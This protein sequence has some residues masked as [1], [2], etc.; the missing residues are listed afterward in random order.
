[1]NALPVITTS[2]SKPL[3][4]SG[5]PSTIS[6]TGANTYTWS[7]N[8]TGTATVVNPT[9]ATVYVVTGKESATG[10]TN[11]ATAQVAVFIPTFALTSNTS[12]CIGG[13]I[14]LNGSGA[15][16]YTWNADPTKTTPFLAVSP[17]VATI[18]TLTGKSTSVSVVC[19]ADQTVQVGI[20]NQPTVTA[21]SQK[22]VICRNENVQLFAG[23]A[24]TYNWSN[25]MTGG[26]ITVAP[27]NQ[28]TFTVIG[29]DI[30]N[31]KDTVAVVVKVQSCLGLNEYSSGASGISV[32]PNPS[33]GNFTIASKLNV[34]LSVVDEL[35]RVVRSVS[36]TEANNRT[37]NVA[38]LPP[39]IY[40][41]TGKEAGGENVAFKV[42]VE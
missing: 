41:V 5:F 1:V 8:T 10:C 39:G 36:L 13:T 34:S 35:G 14:V 28:S 26:T 29:T 30:Y 38:T 25:G 6:A 23:G 32:Y 21:V 27:V 42:V 15:Q 11:V 24:S 17:S 33:T 37:E 18:Y 16:S 4:C 19:T 40:F 12:I 9:V 7:T 2:V 22:S 31:C 3:V 20:Y